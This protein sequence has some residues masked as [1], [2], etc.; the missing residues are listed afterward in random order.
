MIGTKVQPQL[1]GELLNIIKT[2]YSEPENMRRYEEWKRSK[3]EPYVG[4]QT[5]YGAYGTGPLKSY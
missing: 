3:E 1:C 4:N 5:E 2:F